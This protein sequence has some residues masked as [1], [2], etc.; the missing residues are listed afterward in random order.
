MSYTV[1]LTNTPK[2]NAP[3]VVDKTSTFIS[4]KETIQQNMQFI[5]YRKF[6]QR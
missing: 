2:I 4:K 6:S 1:K 5:D 3:K